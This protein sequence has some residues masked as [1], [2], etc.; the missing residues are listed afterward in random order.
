M[1]F[2]FLVLNRSGCL[3]SLKNDKKMPDRD[4]LPTFYQPSTKR[5]KMKD[6]VSDLDKAGVVYS[7]TTDKVL[8]ERLYEHNRVIDH[9]TAAK[10][11]ASIIQP[12]QTV[13][14]QIARTR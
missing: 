12:S 2:V 5:K 7:C 6:K 9:N 1:T 11:A 14:L 13:E 8:R 4:H 10:R 3:L